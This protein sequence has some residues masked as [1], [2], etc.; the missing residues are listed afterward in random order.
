MVEGGP[1]LHERPLLMRRI[2][3]VDDAEPEGSDV[4][5]LSHP[6][7]GAG[8]RPTSNLFGF[9]VPL[10]FPCTYF[11]QLDAAGEGH[12][13]GGQNQSQ[14]APMCNAYYALPI[15]QRIER[16]HPEK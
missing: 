10:I 7:Q 3:D 12:S 11:F 6:R 4:R 14:I 16:C 15:T 1:R 8:V 2:A 13:P 9:W 5:F